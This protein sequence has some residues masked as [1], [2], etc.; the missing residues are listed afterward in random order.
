MSAVIDLPIA[1]ACTLSITDEAVIGKDL[2]ELLA[3][4][5]YADPLTI[6]RE[7]VQNAADS[8]DEARAHSLPAPEGFGV[9]IQLD[10]ALRTITIRDNGASIP[11]DAFV[12]RLTTV[13]ASGKRGKGLRGFR[14]VGRLSGL[15]YCQELV[16]RGRA[17]GSD[18]VTEMHWD[19]RKLRGLLRDAHYCGSLSELIR[20]VVDV[21]RVPAKAEPSRFFEVQLRRV[22]RLRGDLLLNEDHIRSYLSQVAPVPFHPEFSLGPQIHQFLSE[23]GV[24]EP[25]QIRLQRDAEPI[26]H[27]ARDTIRFSEKLSDFAQTVELLEFRGQDGEV[28]A[29]GWV[30]N[31]SYLGAVSRKEGFGGIRLRAGNIQVGSES[32]LAPLFV[33]P[34]FASWTVGDIHVVSPQI[35]PNGRR[36]DFEPSGP[37]SHLQDELTIFFKR[38]STSIRERSITRNRVRHAEQSLGLADQWLDQARDSD[39][40]ATVASRIREIVDNHVAQAQ[41]HVS[42]LPDDSDEVASLKQ[43]VKTVLQRRGR[44]LPELPPSPGRRSAQDRALDV[45]IGVVL[46][47]AASPHAGLVMSK[48]ILS[49]FASPS[50]S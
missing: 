15:G 41:K 43:R 48:K 20:D 21:R 19:G 3:G 24:R 2:L 34:R 27:R 30:L 46:E 11:D 12:R 45:A 47:S 1:P 49:A 16:F 37:Y 6:F 44:N 42:K 13:G 8:I 35:I 14:G 18:I 32:L 33:E 39:L 38:I 40:P 36:D 25:I 4:A 50:R 9:E 23:R 17:E 7:Y 31:L 28:D 22:T 29:Y 5:M 10:R 26:F